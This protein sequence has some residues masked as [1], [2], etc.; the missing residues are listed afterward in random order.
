MCQEF[1]TQCTMAFSPM[2]FASTHIKS[3]MCHVYNYSGWRIFGK[4][5]IRDGEYS[6]WRIFGK[7]NIREG[8][9][10]QNGQTCQSGKNGRK[11][12][13]TDHTTDHTAARPRY[14]SMRK[15]AG[16]LRGRD[17]PT[18]LSAQ[19]SFKKFEKVAQKKAEKIMKKQKNDKKTAKKRQKNRKK[20]QKNRKKPQKNRKRTAKKNRGR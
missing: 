7:E 19:K 13:T 8:E 4:E 2:I 15:G 9:Y 16:G 20:P 17:L 5:N 10:G 3:G 1:L 12:H 11:G 18:G 6:G 14:L